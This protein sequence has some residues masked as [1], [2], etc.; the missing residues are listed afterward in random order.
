MPVWTSVLVVLLVPVALLFGGLSPM[1]ADSCAPGRCAG[2]LQ[3][4]LAVVAVCWFTS[5]TLTP[6]LV[7]VSWLC[8]GTAVGRWSAW[9][10]LV[11][12]VLVIL[13]VLGVA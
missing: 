2:G 10:A 1:A 13:L 7:L 9:A 8:S 11:P 4:T 3:A 12:P 5:W 6:L